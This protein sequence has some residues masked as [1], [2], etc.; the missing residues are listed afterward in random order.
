MALGKTDGHKDSIA[1]ESGDEEPA[2]EPEIRPQPGSGAALKT[3]L[4][5]T[6]LKRR[7]KR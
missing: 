2:S 3:Q 1:K 6:K 4:K 5:K 7:P